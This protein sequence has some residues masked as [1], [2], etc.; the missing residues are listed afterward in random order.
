MS[1]ET[2]NR[3]TE[4]D[5]RS[6]TAATDVERLYEGMTG[7]QN[8]M[9]DFEKVIQQYAVQILS[10][11]I[12]NEA[13]PRY[14]AGYEAGDYQKEIESHIAAD[15]ESEALLLD[16]GLGFDQARFKTVV[17]EVANSMLQNRAE[18]IKKQKEEV[19]PGIIL[20]GSAVTNRPNLKL[21]P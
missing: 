13:L 3:I 5:N 11:Q 20:P 14:M 18:A 1:Q 9:Q 16:K 17:T 15:P 8:V 21:V 12:M 6:R 2:E 10:S 19:K 7:L 4:I